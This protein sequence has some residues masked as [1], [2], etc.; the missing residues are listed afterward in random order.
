MDRASELATSS[1]P[2]LLLKFSLPAVVGMVVQA[3]YISIDRMFVG[4]GPDLG[5]LAVAATTVAFPFM[6]LQMAVAMLVGFGGA[7]LVSIR[8]GQ[9]RA[10]EAEQ[11]LGNSFT[12]LIALP[13]LLSAAV[14]PALDP[15]LVLF[16]ASPQVLP[17]AHDFVLVLLLGWVLQSV[18]FGLNAVVRAEGSPYI[19]MFTMLLSVLLNAAFAPLFVFVLRWG[20]RGIG[21][22]TVLAQ[23]AGTVWVV[24]HFLGRHSRLKLQWRNLI[25]VDS[26]CRPILL[27]GLPPAALQLAAALLNTLMNHQLRIYG[28]DVAISVMG[29]IYAVVMFSAMP[30]FGIN[31]GVQ[32]IIGFNYG[33][34]HYA[35]V[36]QALMWAVVVAT[37]IATAGFLAAMAVPG[38]IIRTFNPDDAAVLAMGVPAM[39][40]C[41][42][43]F[44]IVGFQV[45]AA[46]YFQAVGKPR[47]SM[48]LSL[49]RQV[50]LLL[51]ALLVLPRFFGLTGV[52]ASLPAADCASALWSLYWLR[53]ELAHLQDGPGDSVA[54]G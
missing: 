27:I 45:V 35:R 20:M 38:L 25:P 54:L 34:G 9:G 8:L 12:L 51:P 5:T 1:I 19:A 47:Q 6:L 31:Q 36:T 41:L 28:G 4:R 43:L 10:N 32:P 37:S 48:L 42:I 24:A 44:P 53:R 49:S 23:A 33:A 30:I 7:A 15:M 50:L 13:I 18:S 2:R 29:V 14:L 3:L 17:Y 52:W 11:A 40:T 39:R 46:S 16:G 21:L 22:A 26:I